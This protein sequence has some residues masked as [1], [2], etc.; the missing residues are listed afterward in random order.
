MGNEVKM[1]WFISIVAIVAVLFTFG[2]I[3]AGADQGLLRE[4]RQPEIVKTK[5]VPDEILVKFKGDPDHFR[6]VKVPDGKVLEKVGEYSKR[7]DV[8]YA[9]PNYYVYALWQPNDQYYPYQWDLDNPDYGGIQME[10][11][12][13]IQTGNAS[14]VVAV[15]DTGV[16]YENYTK[17]LKR[18]YLA[19]DLASTVFVPGYDYVENDTH[20][21][22]D[23]SHGTHVTGTIAQS[24]NNGVGVAGV[25]F[26]TAI[27]PVKVLDKN[28]SGTDANVA[29]G[30]IWAADHGADVINLSLG[31]PDPSQTLLDAV[32]YAYEHG[33]T[34]IAAAGNDGSSQ[35]SYPAA[36]DD[37]VIAVGATRY[38]ETLAYYSNYGAS[39]DLVAPG[40]DLNVDQNKDGYPDGVLQNTFNPNT[41]NTGDFGYWFFQG[42]SMAAPHVS[43]VAAL[44]LAR[45]N[46]ATP[47]EVRAAL[48]GTADDLGAPG[49]DGT[50]G[51]G[52]VNAYV[53]LQWTA[54]PPDTVAPQVTYATGNTATTTGEPVTVS[55]TITD[56][57][58]VV[59]ASVHY[60]PIASTET[61][62]SM[63]EGGSDVWSANVP[64]ASDRVGTI[65]YYITAKDMAGNTARDPETGS[66]NITVTDNDSPLANGGP[67]QSV[68]VNQT[69]I[70]DGSGSTDNV[71]IT[72]YKWDFDVSN[73]VNWAA[74]DGTGV[75]VTTK[76]SLAGTYTVTLQVS[77]AAGLTATDT[78]QI[79]ATE[80]PVAPTA[81]VNIDLSKQTTG[82]RWKATATVTITENSAS[83]PVIA[84]ATVYA[85]W[86]GAYSRAVSGTT[87][88]SGKVIFRTS[89]IRGSGAVTFTATRIVKNGQEYVLSGNTSNF[90]SGP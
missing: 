16:A 65:T 63:T 7:S 31:G 8:D 4:F 54:G 14:V 53:A 83:G 73:G 36:Y 10:E 66:Y 3:P 27:M 87:D 21:N 26:D 70:L 62:V 15:V 57:V 45:G 59:S 5:C 42:T 44:L 25:A 24:T 23:N 77:D 34:V 19:P 43:G 20:P 12:W 90:I 30:I 17:W 6:V 50:Y 55:A 11:A 78:A 84:R 18:Y 22:D 13:G 1:K 2:V 48:Q 39:L 68:T 60:T 85:N 58:D 35:A 81:W 86:S 71:G 76:Y 47:D 49:W 51:W 74:P 88:S 64:A 82:S 75:A 9:E 52:L 69:V 72:T 67:D 61:S 79:T 38:D 80:P 46:A 28:G 32:K 89:F 29:S 37:Y 41:K 33:V 56:N 40:G